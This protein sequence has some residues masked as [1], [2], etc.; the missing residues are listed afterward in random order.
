[1]KRPLWAVL[2][3]GVLMT[4]VAAKGTLDSHRRP[5]PEWIDLELSAEQQAWLDFMQRCHRDNRYSP[6]LF[7]LDEGQRSEVHALGFRS[8]SRL[9]VFDQR[10][11][12]SPVDIHLSHALR[13]SDTL[14]RVPLSALQDEATL[15]RFERDIM[16]WDENPLPLRWSRLGP[17]A[18][19]PGAQPSCE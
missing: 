11:S 3:G 8:P 19:L 12:A 18:R 14:L 7:G 17:E 10:T 15:L 9:V 4:T 2:A 13:I 16:G 6:Y 5:L 1:M